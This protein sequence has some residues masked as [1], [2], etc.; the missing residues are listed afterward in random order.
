M[1][2]PAIRDGYIYG[3][4]SYGEYRCIDAKTG[5]RK[6]ET[7]QPTTGKSSRW[8]N[9]FTVQLG[10]ASDRYIL[11]NEQGD[12]II[13]RLTPKGYEE[14]SRTAL[15]KPTTMPLGARMRARGAAPCPPGTWISGVW[16]A[17]A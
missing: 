4:C 10:E 13:A 17:R 12:L 15:I 14:I 8:G 2:T 11:F 5:E 16:P 1:N 9:A 7:F 6:W 3:A